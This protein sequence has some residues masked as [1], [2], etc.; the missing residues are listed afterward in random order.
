MMQF[1]AVPDGA[2]TGTPTDWHLGHPL[3]ELPYS[4]AFR[5]E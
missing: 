5:K 1:A 3:P 4:R 2:D